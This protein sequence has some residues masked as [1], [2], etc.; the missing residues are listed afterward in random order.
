MPSIP[1]MF[2]RALARRC[3]RCGQG[4]LFSRWFTLTERCPRC[5]LRFEREE[6]AFLGSLALNYGVTAVLFIGTLVV[7]LILALPNVPVIPLTITCIA[8]AALF[9]LIFFP[10]AKLLWTATDLVLHGSKH[11]DSEHGL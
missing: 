4:R 7:W 10:F 6:G 5:G 3:P 1:V 8:I 9:P 11:D 2:L